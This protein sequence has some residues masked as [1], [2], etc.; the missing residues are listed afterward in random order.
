MWMPGTANMPPF[1]PADVAS[2]DC[3]GPTWGKGNAK[4]KQQ[5]DEEDVGIHTGSFL[6]D[7]F[8]INF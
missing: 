5:D 3:P 4:G 1:L 8:K 7:F 2:G 6:K